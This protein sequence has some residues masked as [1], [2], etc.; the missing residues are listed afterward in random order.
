MSDFSDNDA[1]TEAYDA[2]DYIA[3]DYEKALP[4]LS[5]DDR[6]TMMS[7][8]DQLY[9]ILGDKLPEQQLQWIVLNNEY[10]LSASMDAALNAAS[11]ITP[12]A[13]AAV[14]VTKKPAASKKGESIEWGI[15]SSPSRVWYDL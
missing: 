9:D 3:F 10:D 8:V 11:R 1:A 14:T 13:A 6:A 12:P 2:N 4:A 5:D 15:K 7:I